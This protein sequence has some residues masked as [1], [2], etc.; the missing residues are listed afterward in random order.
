MAK[1]EEKTYLKPKLGRTVYCIYH[2]EC[3]FADTVGYLGKDSFIVDSFN[4]CTNED[5]WEWYYGCYNLDWFTSLAK[6]K[7]YLRELLEE[8]GERDFKIVKI[9]DDYYEVKG[10]WEE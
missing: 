9:K 5:S 1:V 7:K 2:D 4:N 3:I 10:K 8:K 6:A